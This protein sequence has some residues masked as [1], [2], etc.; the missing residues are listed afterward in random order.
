MKT[1]ASFLLGVAVG[2]LG[3][4]VF[5]RMEERLEEENDVE[6]AERM[7][8]YMTELEARTEQLT[9]KKATAKRSTAK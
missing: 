3:V 5:R 7:R 1:A 2:A 6:L 8:R 4:A 9:Q